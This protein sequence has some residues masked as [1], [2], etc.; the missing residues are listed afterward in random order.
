L[1][2]RERILAYSADTPLIRPFATLRG[3]FSPQA[4]RRALAAN[5]FV[6]S[7]RPACGERVAEG[8]VRGALVLA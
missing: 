5:V 6:E 4:G 2:I 1:A 8:R 3:T 7:P